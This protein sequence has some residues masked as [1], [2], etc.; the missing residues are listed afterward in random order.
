MHAENAL[1]QQSERHPDGWGVSYYRADA[2]HI[3]KSLNTA[4]NDRLFSHVSGL[5]ASKTVLA[6]LRKATVGKLGILNTHPFQYGRWVFAHNGTLTDYEENKDALSQHIHPELNRFILG[7]TDSEA[8]FYLLLT[9]LQKRRSLD[10]PIFRHEEIF[11]AVHQTTSVLSQIFT[12]YHPQQNFH[13]TSGSSFS[14]V[15]TNGTSL[16]AHHGG[17]ELF[18]STHKTR[19]S[20][21]G[22]CPHLSESCENQVTSGQVN[23]LLIASEPLQ[24]ENIWTEL[25]PRE[26]VAVD[27]DMKFYRS[28]L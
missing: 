22:T 19:C 24:G 1:A 5:V 3:I 15:L 16:I 6:H 28:S 9:E 11:E 8:I 14:F 17:Q 13:L 27:Y 18:Y 2:P 12:D 7:D 26:V 23:H 21:R 20:E 10:Q 4:V 25:K